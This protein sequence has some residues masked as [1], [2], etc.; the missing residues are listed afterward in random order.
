[1]KIVPR[2]PYRNQYKTK[3]QNWPG[4]LFDVN[5]F[6]SLG[7]RK[8]LLTSDCIINCSSL[9]HEY[10]DD[11]PISI[12]STFLTS[13]TN[14]EQ[15][16]RMAKGTRF[17][18]TDVWIFPV[19]LPDECHWTLATAYIGSKTLHVFDSLSNKGN[20]HKIRT[21]SRRLLS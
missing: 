13:S 14:D 16:W 20:E 17:W 15:L 8:S 4:L 6:K 11:R 1:M 12:F 5:L 3:Q 7:S 10:Y 2:G 18:D 9:L 21:V 19:H